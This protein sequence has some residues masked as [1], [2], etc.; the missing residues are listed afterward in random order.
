MTDLHPQDA[1]GGQTIDLFSRLEESAV[2]EVVK[3]R[4]AAGDDPLKIM[5]DCNEGIRRVG[6]Q[7][8][9]GNYYISGLIMSGEIF[10][11]VMDLVQPLLE[12]RFHGHTLGKILLGTVAGDIHDV[13]KNIAGMML[14]CHGF[15]VIDLGIDVPDVEFA[16]KA[17][18]LKPDIV[19][20]SGLITASFESM[21]TTTETLRAISKIYAL[22]FPI[23]IGGSLLD[24]EICR[25]TGADYWVTDVMKGVR[26]CTDIIK[27]RPVSS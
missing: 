26:L 17:A 11:E 6:E 9:Q 8:A 27:K 25:F 1:L 12:D 3:Q 10:R 16:K 18:E 2:L 22:N 24:E 20:L 7:Y 13:G 4:I 14:S 5:E 19:G 21:K 15:T 23:V